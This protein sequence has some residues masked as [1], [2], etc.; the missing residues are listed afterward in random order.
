MTVVIKINNYLYSFNI[1]LSQKRFQGF[2]NINLFHPHK[3]PLSE[4]ITHRKDEKGKEI[5]KSLI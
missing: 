5:F 1:T 4:V 3:N 2:W